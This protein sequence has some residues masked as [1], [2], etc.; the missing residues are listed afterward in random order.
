MINFCF[1]SVRLHW[2]KFLELNQAPNPV[3]LGP[4]P[5][6]IFILI[7]FDIEILQK[8]KCKTLAVQD[9]ASP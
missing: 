6:S 9:C 1:C 2:F 7:F 4:N 5:V 3:R 8:L